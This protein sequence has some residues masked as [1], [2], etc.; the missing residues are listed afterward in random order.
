MFLIQHHITV[1]AF[2]DSIMFLSL[3]PVVSN[4]LAILV[5]SKYAAR[6]PAAVAQPQIAS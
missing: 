1:A 5:R 4:R 6:R 3:A 2:A